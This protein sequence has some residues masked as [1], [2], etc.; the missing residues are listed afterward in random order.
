MW[1]ARR[2]DSLIGVPKLRRLF[3]GRFTGFCL[4]FEAGIVGALA[5]LKTQ[6][7]VRGAIGE[8]WIW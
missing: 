1:L 7:F 3:R 2:L 4:R 5:I 8:G 6:G